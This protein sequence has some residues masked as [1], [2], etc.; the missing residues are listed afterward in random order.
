MANFLIII[1]IAGYILISFETYL[2]INKAA[3][4]LFT[5]ILCWVIYI[6]AVD[7]P[8]RVESALIKSVPGIAGIIFFL[9]SAMTIVELMSSDRSGRWARKGRQRTGGGR[10]PRAS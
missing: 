2:K 5:G 1:F 4:A 7:D 3:I 9:L 10:D 8:N 6:A